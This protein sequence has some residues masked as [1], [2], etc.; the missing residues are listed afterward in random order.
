MPDGIPYHENN[1]LLSFFYELKMEFINRLH[2]ESPDLNIHLGDSEAFF[3]PVKNL[4]TGQ[5]C[6][7][8]MMSGSRKFS[9]G[10]NV[11]Q[12]DHNQ[13]ERLSRLLLEQSSEILKQL[14]QEMAGTPPDM[15]IYNSNSA[16]ILHYPGTEKANATNRLIADGLVEE[17]H[18]IGDSTQDYLGKNSILRHYA[19][20]NAQ[21]AFSEICIFQSEKPHTGGV[22][23]IIDWILKH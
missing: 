18:M 21:S 6:S 12:K 20:G 5:E 17:I 15:G 1:E 13:S 9:I 10:Y 4:M 14:F 23:D 8:L 16:C 2:E 22:I 11:F 3:H 19:V 7:F